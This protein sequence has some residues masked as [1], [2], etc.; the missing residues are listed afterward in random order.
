MQPFVPVLLGSDVN[1]YGMARSFHEAYGITSVAIGKGRLGATS[2]SRIVSVDVVESRLEEDDVFCETLL[3]F[4]ERYPSDTPL[5]LVP[6]GDNYMKLLVRNQDA[7]RDRYRFACIDEQL[8]MQLETKESFYGLCEKYGFAYPKTMT[9]TVNSYQT[10]EIPFAFPVVIKPSNSVAYW[11]CRFPHKKKVFIAEDKSEFDAI[12]AA[13]Y[14]SSYQDHLIV[15]EYIPGDDSHMRVMNCYSDKDKKV[16]LIA[17][18]QALLEEHSPEGIG[19]YAAIIPVEDRQL[20][21][22]MKAFLEDIGYI[23]FSNFDFKFDS[24]DGQYKIFE[25]NPRQGRSSF[26]VTAEGY[27]LAQYLVEDVLLDKPAECTIA[28]GETLWTLIPKQLIFEYVEDEELKKKARQLLRKRK[29]C[30]SLYYK[31]DRN[32]RRWVYFQKNQ[33][34]YFKKYARYF[35]NKGLRD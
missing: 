14:G 2:N 33:A 3:R 17:L 1:V 15:Q 24:R 31:K 16:R 32:F 4:A 9:V 6:C 10:A 13:I 5:L 35:G 8:L 11:N 19:S 7:L 27:N 23:G 20:A 21:R 26:F 12:T 18:G 25:M 34:G 30:R 28:N 22:Q 29:L